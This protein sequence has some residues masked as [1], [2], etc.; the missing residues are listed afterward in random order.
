MPRLSSTDTI[1]KLALDLIHALRNPAPA[2]P[3]TKLGE[4]RLAALHQLATIFCTATTQS[5]P[6]VAASKPSTDAT[7]THREQPYYNTC[8]QQRLQQCHHVQTL[9]SSKNMMITPEMNGSPS[10][11]L[12]NAVI[13]PDTGKAQ[14]YRQLIAD[15]KT[16]GV[17]LH[18]A[19]NEFGRLAQGV[20][21]HIEGTKTIKFISR[22]QVPAGRTITYAHFCANIRPQM[23]ET[24]QYY[25]GEVSKKTAGWTTIKLLLNS[26]VSKPTARFMTA[27]VKTFY[28]NTPL[29]RP[30]YMRIPIKLIPQEII[31]D[32]KL[33][34]LV[35]HDYVYVEINKGMYGL[36]QAGLL[37]NKL[38]PRRLAKYGYYQAT[39][40][41]TWPLEAHLMPHPIRTSG[42][43]LR[44]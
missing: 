14:E 10:F 21:T 17:W 24:H 6:R 31:D 4:E 25:P 28:L 40:P 19:A 13:D 22:S 1:T 2:A 44:R 12:A 18:A 15:P 3:F 32:Y 16:R 36:P 38:L 34:P 43:R 33:Q 8:L 9:P 42:G 11:P 23:A 5:P 35:H 29:E 41:H 27:D 20:K 37:A 30:E 39:R 7:N 26:V